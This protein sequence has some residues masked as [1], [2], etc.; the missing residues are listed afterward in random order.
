MTRGE[1]GKLTKAQ[2]E[3]LRESVSCC[4]CVESYRP[5]QRLV[6][7]GLCTWTQGS[8]GAS[9]LNITETGL[10]TLKSLEAREP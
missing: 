5:A 3:T 2:I 4:P 6:E 9:Y 8:F 1:I 10:A 7:L